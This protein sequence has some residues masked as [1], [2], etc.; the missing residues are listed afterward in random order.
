M[1]RV[2]RVLDIQCTAKNRQRG[3]KRQKEGG[4]GAGR[5]EEAEPSGTRWQRARASIRIVIVYFR[6]MGQCT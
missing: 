6:C 5:V 1:Y 4:Y 2:R 3:A